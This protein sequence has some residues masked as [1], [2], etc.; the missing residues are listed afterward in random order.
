MTATTFK[1]GYKQ[2][3]LGEIPEDWDVKSI[4][5]LTPQGKKFGIVDGPFGSNL[6]T[7]HYR[8][9]GI[10]IITS[11]YV[12]D[13][14]F[15][16]S[17]YLY[18]DLDKFKQERR[19]AVKG[20]DIVMAK[21]GE[22]CGAS[23]VL[24]KEHPES[25][26]SGNALKISIDEG[27]FSTELIAQILWRHHVIG[28]LELLRTT[29]AQPAI[30]MANLKKYRIAIPATKIEQTTIANVLSD[31]DALIEPLEKLITK[32]KAIKQGTMQ[33]LLPGKK[34]LPGFEKK[35]Y[36]QTELG[37]IPED[38]NVEKLGAIADITKLA[39]FEY[40]NY[41]NSYKD[42]GEIVVIRG[43]NITHNKLD[44]ADIRT[45]PRSTSNMLPRSKLSQHDLVFAYVG[46][47][48][49]VFL[50]DKDDAYHLGPNTAKITAHDCMS[51]EFLFTYF[52][53]WIMKNEIVE[54][55]SIGAQPSLSMTKIRKFRV[56]LPKDRFEQIA[57]AT[58][59]SDMDA[60]IESLEQKRDKYNMIKQG[61]M[62][63][64]LTGK[65]RLV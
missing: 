12:T 33:Q 65:T 23:A 10:P 61:M 20:G 28:N 51:P 22:R 27:K 38:W 47:I 7:I 49:P 46:T 43:T 19:S 37:A 56:V 58:V 36:K 34:R 6:K 50:I 48:G 60:E 15:Y 30:S 25:I 4:E 54:H 1:K 45:I 9:S 24:P 11:G 32:K 14:K 57:I 26:L 17:E 44:L 8:K 52:T 13:G 40:T 3:E 29:G 39:G 42:G 41:F 63:E 18:V 2:T 31:T 53:S 64:L 59:L 62:Q 16:A 55:T 21:I 5:D 35:G